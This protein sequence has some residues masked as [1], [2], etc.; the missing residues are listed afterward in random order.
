MPV[1]LKNVELFIDQHPE[2]R[3]QRELILARA[4]KKL[5][6][7]SLLPGREVEQLLGELAQTFFEE[8]AH[9]KD[10]IQIILDAN[11]AATSSLT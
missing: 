9:S 3:C 1:A 6:P 11:P 2:L 10:H 5:L 4:R 8:F 7:N